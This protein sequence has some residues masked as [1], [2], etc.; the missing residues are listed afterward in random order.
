M[1]GGAPVTSDPVEVVRRF[2]EAIN[3]AD[4][5]GLVALMTED[6]RFVDALGREV[7]GRDAMGGAWS[8]Y[9]ELFPDYRIDVGEIL[10]SGRRVAVFGSAAGTYGG[11]AGG[12]ADDHWSGP[13][14][15]RAE[16]REGLV[17][18]WRVYADTGPARKIIE[19]REGRR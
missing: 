17:A 5:A 10:G 16:V 3:A 18:E 12:S 6:H 19:R 13:A 1:T 2:V 7:T 8:A 9:F 4:V 11:P 14:A 15:W